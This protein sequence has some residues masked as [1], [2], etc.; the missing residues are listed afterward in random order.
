M[1]NTKLDSGKME[2][3]ADRKRGGHKKK[4]LCGCKYLGRAP[5]KQMKQTHSRVIPQQGPG[6]LHISDL[7]TTVRLRFNKSSTTRHGP[8]NT[9]AYSNLFH[10]EGWE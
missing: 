10:N 4:C 9:H 7:H 5:E 6:Y 3:A 2:E 1:E 8:R